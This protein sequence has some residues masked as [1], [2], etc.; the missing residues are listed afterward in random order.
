MAEFK[1][2][3]FYFHGYIDC[4]EKYFNNFNPKAVAEFGVFQGDSIRWLL[5][6][7]PNAVIHGADIIPYQPTWPVD[8][9]FF[10]TQLDQGNTAQVQNFLKLANYDL[11]IEDGSHIPNHQARCLVEGIRALHKGGIYI[12]EDIHTSFEE[13]VKTWF[14]AEQTTSNAFNVLFAIDHYKRINK[15][16]DT[17]AAN[18]IAANSMFSADE[19]L[20]LAYNI[21]EIFLYKRNH[22][23]NQCWACGSQDFDYLRLKCY[24]GVNLFLPNDSMSFV[25]RKK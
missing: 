18:K 24:C 5:N 3:K 14:G 25:I 6:R 2:D 15:F 17:A 9:R 20:E 23:P 8:D 11:I 21:D 7:F 22:L 13:H 4:Y 10:F 12:L 16:I 1:T 19:V